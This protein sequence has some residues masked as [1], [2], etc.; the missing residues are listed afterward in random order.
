ME[1]SNKSSGKWFLKADS[2]PLQPGWAVAPTSVVCRNGVLS[3]HFVQTEEL[4]DGFRV[5][6][7]TRQAAQ[8]F[9][10][11]HRESDEK[12][13]AYASHWGLLGVRR[14]GNL[15][16]FEPSDEPCEGWR[17]FSK[18]AKAIL[19]IA[20]HIKGDEFGLAEDWALLEAGHYFELKRYMSDTDP[21]RPRMQEERDR[22]AE[23]VNGWI[24]LGGLRPYLDWWVEKRQWRV[25]LIGADAHGRPTAGIF[26]VLTRELILLLSEVSAFA[27]CSACGQSYLPERMP[28][29]T[30]RN[31]CGDCREAGRPNLDAANDHRARQNKGRTRK[32]NHGKTR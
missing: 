10:W 27:I 4:S 21:K 8:Q 18:E 22:L 30:K 7:F 29:P 3:G 9:V 15:G 14:W 28:T 12:I 13:A 6:Q 17:R 31:Y 5:V 2:R 1:T 24:A 19:D 16:K 25:S 23:A 20:G 26:G 11:L 32:S